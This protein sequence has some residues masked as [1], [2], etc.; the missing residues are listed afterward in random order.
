MAALYAGFQYPHGEI[1]VTMDA[2][3]Q[4]DPADLPQMF[5]L[6]GDNKMVNGWRHQRRD[7]L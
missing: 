5:A 7:S 6:F 4:N 3:L 1:I 2:D